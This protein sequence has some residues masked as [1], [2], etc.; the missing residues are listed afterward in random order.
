M[1]R[2]APAVEAPYGTPLK[3]YTSSRLKPRILPA[4]VSATVAPSEAVTKVRQPP[5]PELGFERESDLG[6]DS[7]V[8]REKTEPAKAA[9]K[10]AKRRIKERRSLKQDPDSRLS[11]FVDVVIF[12]FQLKDL[13]VIA[14]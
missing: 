5:V 4:V 6:C 12:T 8:V 9:P 1:K 3:M 11:T 2:R 10:V 14:L 13:D 7:A